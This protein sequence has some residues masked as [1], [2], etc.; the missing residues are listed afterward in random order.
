ARHIV[1]V[2]LALAGLAAIAF[3]DVLTIRRRGQAVAW[4]RLWPILV[5]VALS[6]ATSVAGVTLAGTPWAAARFLLFSGAARAAFGTLLIVVAAALL[7]LAARGV[8]GAAIAL[9]LFTA[10]DLAAWGY[11]YVFQSAPQTIEAIAA[12]ANVPADAQPGD[13]VTP[14]ANL[15]E[16]NVGVLR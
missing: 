16:A 13:Y 7:V 11:G 15:F 9:A 10:A 12:R 4:R 8:R 1:L 2:H 3:E 5:P 14:P 6:V